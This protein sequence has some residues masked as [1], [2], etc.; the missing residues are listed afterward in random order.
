LQQ[1]AGRLTDRQSVS[2]AVD[3]E[4]VL[5][6]GVLNE[7]LAQS[8]SLQGKNIEAIAKSLSSVQGIT[9]SVASDALE[10]TVLIDFLSAPTELT[11][12]AKVFFAEVL[13]ARGMQLDEFSQWKMSAVSEGKTLSFTGPIASETLDDLLGMFTVHRAS[14]G[15]TTVS[16]TDSPAAPTSGQTSP[17]IVAENTRDY[18]RKVI[19]IVHRVRDYSA[20]NT[21]ERAQWN[22]NMANRIDEMPT[23][24]VDPQMVMFG[25]EVAKSL[26]S[27]S[28][29]MQLTNISQ[30]AAA[31][32]ADAGTGAFS[33]A[34]AVG[35]MAGMGYGYG[36]YGNYGSYGGNFVD[37][38]SPVKYYRMGQAQGNTSFKELMARLE[39]SL[40]DMRRTMTEKYKI[41]F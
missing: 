16:K 34:T 2:I 20:N 38:N 41:Q 24:E 15:V 39:Q 28:M 21:G 33:T 14:R 8:K 31:V 36:G 30:G 7:K 40:A 35:T 22:G 1:V 4:D 12:V 11:P 23:L 32:A 19:N 6:M 27:N 18:F 26:R 29:S 37:P 13:T 5:S 25:A 3:L 17:S 10:A 9:I